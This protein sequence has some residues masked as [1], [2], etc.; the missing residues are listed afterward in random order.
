LLGSER[1][2]SCSCIRYIDQG[3]SFAPFV[4]EESEVFDFK[5]ALVG[6]E[7]FFDIEEKLHA[8]GD[9]LVEEEG[10]VFFGVFVGIGC[11]EKDEKWDKDKKRVFIG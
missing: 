2:W 8:L 7:A 9:W 3:C 1:A 10:T 4:A 5:G 11:E 6:V